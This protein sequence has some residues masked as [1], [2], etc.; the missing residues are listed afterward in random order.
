MEMDFDFMPYITL[1]TRFDE[2]DAH[3]E[4]RLPSARLHGRI[5]RNLR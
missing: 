4:A 5:R 2:S 3:R 1:A